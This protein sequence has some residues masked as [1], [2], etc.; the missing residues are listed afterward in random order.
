MAR[1]RPTLAENDLHLVPEATGRELHAKNLKSE[2]SND[3][4]KPATHLNRPLGDFWRLQKTHLNRP[5]TLEPATKILIFDEF[6]IEQS[7]G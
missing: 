3:S 5:L 1:Y 6:L 2:Y 4:L 7:N